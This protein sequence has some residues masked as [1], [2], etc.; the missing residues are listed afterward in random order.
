MN[1][2]Y[3]YIYG[4]VIYDKKKQIKMVKEL[5]D[6]YNR[7]FDIKNGDQEYII[8]QNYLC[9]LAYILEFYNIFFKPEAYKNEHE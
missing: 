8:N 9:E 3:D 2:K 5:L 4:E 1:D 6:S 7:D